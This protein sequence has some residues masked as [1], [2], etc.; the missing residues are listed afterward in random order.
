MLFA[1]LPYVQNAVGPH[2]L[3]NCDEMGAALVMKHV[4]N[5]WQREQDN[6]VLAIHFTVKG[7]NQLYVTNNTEQFGKWV[8]QVVR[9]I[10]KKTSL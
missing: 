5:S 3:M 10:K 9:A 6:A 8:C 2:L 7:V 1:S 4:M